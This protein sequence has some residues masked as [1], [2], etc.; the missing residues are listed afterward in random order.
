[1]TV[2]ASVSTPDP[3]TAQAVPAVELRDVGKI[4]TAGAVTALED[5]RLTVAAGEFVSLIGPSGCGKSTLLRIVADLEQPSSG[6]VVVHGKTARQARLDQDYGIAFQQAGLL[7]WR[8]VQ[9]NVELP[10]QLHGVGKKERRARSAELL[11]I[12]GLGDFARR[13]PAEL[14]GGMQQRVAIARALARKP[15][16]LL[17]DE[18]FGALDE[19]TRERMQGELLRIAEETGAAVLFVTHSIPEAVFLSGRVVVMSP[20]PGRITEVLATGGW[21]RDSEDDVRS[22]EE[23]FSAVAAVRA[24]LH[25]GH[26]GAGTPKSTAGRDM[27]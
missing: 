3:A 10:L 9:E 12:T 14:S 6:T 24:A 16:L 18:P 22:G 26:G 11:E 27:R 8:T 5:V 25:E 20:R 4:F 23:F 2:E 15:P 13:F 1:M 21:D 19:M 17:M 7:D